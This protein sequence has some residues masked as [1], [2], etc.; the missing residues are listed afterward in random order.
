MFPWTGAV[1][2]QLY[3]LYLLNE[4]TKLVER[5]GE[6]AWAR[7]SCSFN[8]LVGKINK[9]LE[10]QRPGDTIMK[11]EFPPIDQD[12]MVSPHAQE[13]EYALILSRM[14]NTVKEDPAQLRLTVYEFARTRLKMDTS[15]A[16]E[17]ER[18]RLL[19]ALETAIQGV[20]QFSAR[21]EE[22]ER[23]QPPIPSPQI[24]QGRS[25]GGPSSM[26]MAKT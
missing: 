21:R 5:C 4:L 7:K 25:S 19:T 2:P 15:W 18:K 17:S 9:I 1:L 6:P 20:E 16:E 12:R 14:I 26:S 3:S 10:T 8:G 23:L 13:I 22:K 24:G 11:S